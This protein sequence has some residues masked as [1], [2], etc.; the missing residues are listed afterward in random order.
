MASKKKFM[1]LKDIIPIYFPI[2]PLPAT[3]DAKEREE[4]LKNISPVLN[5]GR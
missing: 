5:N 4:T 2:V 3:K 1:Q